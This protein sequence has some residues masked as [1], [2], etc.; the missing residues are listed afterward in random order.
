MTDIRKAMQDFVHQQ[1]DDESSVP[2][3]S[4][5]MLTEVGARS[6]CQEWSKSM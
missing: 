5:R 1:Y 2:R 6:H 3:G 4:I